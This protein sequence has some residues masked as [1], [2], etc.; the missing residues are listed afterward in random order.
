[1]NLIEA[2][3]K[4]LDRNKELLQLYK[5]IPTGMFGA[6]MIESKITEAEKA[7]ASGDTVAMVHCLKELRNSE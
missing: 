2:L 4:E 7:I 3:Q 1:M 5:S 6:M